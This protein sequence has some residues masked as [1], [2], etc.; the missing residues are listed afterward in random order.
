MILNVKEKTSW[1]INSPIYCE[2]ILCSRLFIRSNGKV[3]PPTEENEAAF[4]LFCELGISSQD[5]FCL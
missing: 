5:Y 4:W 3:Y 1:C 2:V